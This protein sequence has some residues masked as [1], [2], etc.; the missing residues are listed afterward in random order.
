MQALRQEFYA[1]EAAKEAKYAAQEQRRQEKR[2]ASRRRRDEAAERKRARSR[3]NSEKTAH[4]VTTTTDQISA[5]GYESTTPQPGPA[6]VDEEL[7]WIRRGKKPPQQREREERMR[8]AQ[9]QQQQQGGNG[10]GA[11][12]V[13]KKAKAVSNWW[14]VFLFRVKTEWLKVKRGMGCFS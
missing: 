3:A 10:A 8:R 4:S 12:S 1:R 7:E 11:N 6:L 13:G 14:G 9:Q 5:I 2:E